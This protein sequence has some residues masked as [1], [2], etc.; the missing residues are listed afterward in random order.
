[1][2]SVWLQSVKSGQQFGPVATHSCPSWELKNWT[3][4]DFRTLAMSQTTF[5]NYLILRPY[6]SDLEALMYGVNHQVTTTYLFW[7]IGSIS[8]SNI[9][10]MINPSLQLCLSLLTQVALPI[11]SFTIT[12]LGESPQTS[13][14]WTWD[15]WWIEC[16]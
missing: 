7:Q 2:Y 3:K 8:F 14:Y 4:P 13:F 9:S 6:L 1:L 16:D 12:R 5:S 15:I 10:M 11:M